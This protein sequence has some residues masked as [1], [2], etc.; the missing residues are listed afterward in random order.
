MCILKGF[1]AIL[2][3]A[4]IVFIF[5]YIKR[6]LSFKKFRKFIQDGDFDSVEVYT[7]FYDDEWT[8]KDK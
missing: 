2:L 6:R 4:L 7:G 5:L 3:I 1:G 8:G